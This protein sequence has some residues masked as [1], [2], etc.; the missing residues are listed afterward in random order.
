M[1]LMMMMM[2]TVVDIVIVYVADDNDGDVA[3][4]NGDQLVIC[5]FIKSFIYHNNF[6]KMHLSVNFRFL[7]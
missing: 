7:K 3:V 4:D 2:M 1:M 5:L 6:V